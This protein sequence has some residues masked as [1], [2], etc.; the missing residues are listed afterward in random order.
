MREGEGPLGRVNSSTAQPRCLAAQWGVSRAGLQVMRSHEKSGEKR[1][2]ARQASAQH[3]TSAWCRIGLAL[4]D[5][6][7]GRGCAIKFHT[8]RLE[9]LM[10]VLKAWRRATATIHGFHTTSGVKPSLRLVVY[11][12]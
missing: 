1:E 9:L 8:S 4:A 2:K 12:K 7:M 6:S 11:D 5:G 3:R 10:C